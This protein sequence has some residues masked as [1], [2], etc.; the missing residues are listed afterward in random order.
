MRLATADAAEE[1]VDD[2]SDVALVMARRSRRVAVVVVE[3]IMVFSCAFAERGCGSFY[4]NLRH[5]YA[6]I[7]F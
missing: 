5:F 4:V 3:F 1:A 6:M 2:D 7:M